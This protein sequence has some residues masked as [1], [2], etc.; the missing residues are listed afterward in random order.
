MP[1]TVI[2]NLTDISL[3]ESPFTGW[4]NTG[5]GT[6]GLHDTTVFDQIQGSYCYQDSKNSAGNRGAQWDFGAGTPANFTGK[7]LVIWFAFSKKNFGANPMVFK[8]TDTSGNWSEWNMFSQGDLLHSAWI[9]WV[10]NPSVTRDTGSGT[11]VLSEIRYFEWKS[12]TVTAKVF[13]YWDAVRYGTGLS[14]KG[15][16]SGSPATF[17]D[18]ITAENTNAYGVIEKKNTI[19]FTQGNIIIG[20]TTNGDATYFED[21]NKVL[22]FKDIYK[23]PTNFYEIKGQGNTTGETKIFLGEKSGT[24][25]ISGCFITASSTMKF[26]LTMSDT[27]ITEFG[28]YGSTFVNANTITGQAYSTLKEFLGSSFIACAEMLPDTGIVTQCFFISSPGRGIRITGI[29]H[30]ITNCKFI[31]CGHAIHCNFSDSAPGVEFNNLI[32]SGSNGTTKWDVE[33]SV[34]GSLLIKNVGTS[35]TDENYV[36]ETGGGNTNVQVSIT[37]KMMVTNEAGNGINGALAYIDD[38]D[39]TPYIMNTVTAQVE[40]VDGVATVGY[41]GSPVNGSRWRVRKYGYKNF[42]QLVDIGSS[43]ITLYITLVVDPQ[44]T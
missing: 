41:V 1:G 42:K 35:N 5:V 11:L 6:Q 15:G 23:T 25:G 39:E 22:R 12:A 9:P 2:P 30:Y 8:L 17:E 29:T 4:T 27:Y 37:L 10:L 24:A 44:Q 40:G 16:T 21:T 36:E 43:D 19:Y 18:F 26:K 3:C 34:S 13:I 7:F 20:S 28:F 31:D 38:N 33:H 14:I 32:F